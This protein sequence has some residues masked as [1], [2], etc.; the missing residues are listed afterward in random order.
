MPIWEA[1]VLILSSINLNAQ[2]ISGDYFIKDSVFFLSDIF[3]MKQ[4]NRAKNLPLLYLLW[5]FNLQIGSLGGS[6]NGKLEM[7]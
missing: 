2:N 3:D 1:L 6:N 7:E 4:V 5:G